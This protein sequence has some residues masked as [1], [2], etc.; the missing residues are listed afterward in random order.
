MF[1][2]PPLKPKA[3][4]APCPWSAPLVRPLVRI[5]ELQIDP[6]QL[7]PYTAALKTEI[8]QSVQTEPGVL[9]LYA[10]A[11]TQDPTRIRLF[12][13][14]ADEA[15]YQAHLQSAHFKHYKVA[16]EAMV[17]SLRLVEG[18]AGVDGGEGGVGR[19]RLTERG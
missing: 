3:A 1:P 10:V 12:E 18:D 14:Y 5:A 2:A 19:Q 13:I 8:T 15:A 6:A 4:I 9:A 7:A 17:R 11:E 16:T